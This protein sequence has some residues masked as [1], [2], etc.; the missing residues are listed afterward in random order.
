MIL[1]T[2]LIL[3]KHGPL[4]SSPGFSLIEDKEITSPFQLY[5]LFQPF[6]DNPAN[7]DNAVNTTSS[8]PLRLY[9][10]YHYCNR[11][12]SFIT[13]RSQMQQ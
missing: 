3:C 7:E 2:S 10:Y 11:N 9:H 1:S 4:I 13:L 6:K 5:N 12:L 8:V